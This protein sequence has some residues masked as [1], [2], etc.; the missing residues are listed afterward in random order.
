MKGEC[1]GGGPGYG[2][3]KRDVQESDQGCGKGLVEGDED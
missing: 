1:S 2:E 3:V